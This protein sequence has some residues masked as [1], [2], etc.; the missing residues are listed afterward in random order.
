MQALHDISDVPLP[1]TDR[2]GSGSCA[3]RYT[4]WVEDELA[5]PV[6]GP[7]V[8]ETWIP[9]SNDAKNGVRIGNHCQISKK[10]LSVTQRARKVDT[11]GYSD[12]LAYQIMMR[13]KELR[14]DV[15][16]TLLCEQGSVEPA[17]EDSATQTAGLGAWITQG[18]FAGDA[19]GGG[20]SNGLITARTPGTKRALSF[21]TLM[22]VVQDIW[23]DGGEP[24]LLTSHPSVTR[25]LIEFCVAENQQ[26]V[27]MTNEVGSTGAQA[28]RLVKTLL[29]EWDFAISILPNRMQQAY[30]SLGGSTGDAASVFL[31]DPAYLQIGYLEGYVTEE[32]GRR[33]LPH[34]RFMTVD[35]QS[36]VLNRNAHGQIGDIDISLPVA[37]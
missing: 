24:S 9:G 16:A 34:E 23:M 20:F 10:S 37:A 7:G 35:W 2:I 15:E 29:T 28:N 30:D 6:A 12:E 26:L 8:A 31:L 13:Q 33:G 25:K 36:Q 27:D 3:H 32:M 18:D 14:R 22:D 1:I 11:I 21:T 19:A 4:S 5:A 17:T